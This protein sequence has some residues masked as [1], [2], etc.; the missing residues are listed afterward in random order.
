MRL[1][2]LWALVAIFLPAGAGVFAQRPVVSRT[3]V[4]PKTAQPKFAK[5]RADLLIRV[6]MDQDARNALLAEMRSMSA[7][8]FSKPNRKPSALMAQVEAVDRTNVVWLKKI[9]RKVGWPGKT[10]VGH[11]GAS[12]AWLLVQHADKDPQFQKRCLA[13]MQP[14]LAAGEISKI[15]FAYLTDRLLVADKKPQRYGTQIDMNKGAMKPFPTEDPANLD[16]RRASVGLMPMAKYIELVKD[17]YV[18]KKNA[19]TPHPAAPPKPGPA[20]GPGRKP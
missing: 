18:G 7:A 16:K 6:K 12:S 1:L 3:G 9:V 15:D 11:D 10:M 14:M 2:P 5:L 13:L 20:P 17:M 19:P 4:Q 8:D